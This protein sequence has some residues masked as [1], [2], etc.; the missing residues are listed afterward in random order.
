[1]GRGGK[2]MSPLCEGLGMSDI[3][4]CMKASCCTCCAV[5]EIAEAAGGSYGSGCMTY[6]CISCCFGPRVADMYHGCETAQKLR[7]RRGVNKHEGVIKTCMCHVLTGGCMCPCAKIQELRFAR[8]VNKCI[9]RG[10]LFQA[11]WGPKKCPKRQR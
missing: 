11:I 5:G 9:S 8:K 4:A 1:M 2:V 3:C 6:C 10:G 7:K